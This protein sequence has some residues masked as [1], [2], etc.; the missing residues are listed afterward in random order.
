MN[1]KISRLI[2]VLLQFS[3]KGGDNCIDVIYGIIDTCIDTCNSSYNRTVVSTFPW[4]IPR[5]LKRLTFWE[6]YNL[7]SFGVKYLVLLTL[8][9]S[10]PKLIDRNKCHRFDDL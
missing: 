10:S 4:Y 7:G 2:N 8:V 6:L 1:L 5:A 3:E 9:Y